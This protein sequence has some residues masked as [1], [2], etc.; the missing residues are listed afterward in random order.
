MYHPKIQT[1]YVTSLL[2]IKKAMD[3]GSSMA[4]TIQ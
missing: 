3:V 4:G 1:A 2:I